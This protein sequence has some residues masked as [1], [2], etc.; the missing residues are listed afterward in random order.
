MYVLGLN[1]GEIN[2]SAALVKD[3]RILRGCP[4]ERFNRQ[5]KSKAFPR[6]SIE[7]CLREAGIELDDCDAFAQAWNPGAAWQKFNPLISG[8][9]T[10]RED[11]FYSL[12]DNLLGM[13]GRKHLDWVRM[14]FDESC[15]LGPIYYLQHHRAHAA[16][17][18]FLSPF[19][20]AAILTCDLRGEFECTT[21]AHGAG[22]RIEVLQTQHI[23]NSLGMYYAAFTEFL[24]YRSDN[25][26][27]KVMA[28]SAFDVECRALTDKIRGTL[29]L[30]DDGTLELD[31]SFYT[32]AVPDQPKLY[33]AKL[34]ELLGSWEGRPGEEPNERYYAVARAMQIVAEEVALHFLDHLYR[35]TG[36]RSL[37]LSGGFFMNSVFNG[38]VLDRT[39]FRDLYVSYA[40]ADVGNSIGA[41]LYVS[42]CLNGVARHHGCN[43]SL[44]GPSFADDEIEAALARRAISYRRVDAMER[45]IASRLCDGAIVAV[46]NGAM[47][48]GERALGNRSV[49][50]DP[51]RAD[52]KDK[53]NAGIKYRESYRPFA[54]AVLEE[55]A[56]EYFD[57]PPGF[58]APYMEKVVPVREQYRDAL[59]AITHVDGSARPQTVRRDE[60]PYFHR[61]ISEF[62]AATGFP[63]VLNTSFN[64]NGEPIVLSP[65]DALTTFFNSGLR[66]LA[67]GSF[68]VE[69]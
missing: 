4:E 33:S 13:N 53:I 61:V 41:A 15:G 12:P 38:K 40:P 62:G 47:E 51:R 57:V 46:F 64:I 54:P 69:K 24:G 17:A 31:Q 45:T 48:F 50:A 35:R 18:F 28:L 65:D 2:S 10:R 39:P 67:M 16:N 37:A 14:E 8:V 68:L 42:H 58:Q 5:Q 66:C 59:P 21:S 49:L 6:R 32:G 29:R 19:E 30:N 11:Y 63:M 34:V 9:R 25:D 23:P 1:H 60:N 43:S 56:P 22:T 55:K 26:E 52:V 36:C 27:W 20:E 7:F 3:G 44:I